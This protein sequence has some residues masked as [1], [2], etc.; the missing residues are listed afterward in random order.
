MQAISTQTMSSFLPLYREGCLGYKG[1]IQTML[2][3]YE[4]DVSK[5]KEYRDTQHYT[6]IE[7]LLLMCWDCPDEYTE[8]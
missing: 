7:L 4:R 2:E 3:Y 6:I 8:L 5:L 1:Q